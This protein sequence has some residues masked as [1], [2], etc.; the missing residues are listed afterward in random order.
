MERLIHEVARPGPSA[1]PLVPQDR[2]RAPELPRPE[3][4]E[5]DDAAVDVAKGQR[6]ITASVQISGEWDGVV[7]LNTPGELARKFAGIMFEIE[8]DEATDE[9]IEDAMGELANMTGGSYKSLLEGTCELGLPVVTDGIDY[10]VRFPGSRVD[11]EVGF[12]SEGVPFHVTVLVRD[13]DGS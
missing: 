11:S 6:Y 10:I 13:E 8:P 9:D 7:S 12:D 2:P 1:D 5:P 4:A 3:E